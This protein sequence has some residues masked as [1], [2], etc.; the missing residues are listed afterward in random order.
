MMKHVRS[1]L[2]PSPAMVVAGLALAISLGGT[3]YAMT[4]LPRNSVDTPQLKGNAVVSAKVKNGSLRAVDFA[5]DQLP[6]GRAGPQGPAGPAGPKGATGA[7]G[8]AGPAGPKGDTG[9]QGAA[10]PGG[11]Q[12]P[13]GVLSGQ[14][15]SGGGPNPSST[16]QFFSIP[17]TVTVPSPSARVL[18]VAENAFGAGSSGALFLNLYV[19]YQ[20]PGGQLTTVGNGMLGIA[21]APNT[22]VP[23][24][25]NRILTL[26]PGQYVVG[27]CGNTTGTGQ[28]GGWTNNDWGITTALVFNQ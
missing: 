8:A 24:G 20:Q 4:S 23:M 19:C 27:M 6:A 28:A 15:A 25:I 2:V 1:R 18:V 11:A 22:R 13:S 17:V 9:A 3:G 10:G 21:L 26:A 16:L 5:A 7:Q 12:G 14:T